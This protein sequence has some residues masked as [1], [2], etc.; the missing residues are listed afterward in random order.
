MKNICS[1]LL[2]FALCFCVALTSCSENE[3]QAKPVANDTSVTTDA[4]STA[5]SHVGEQNASEPV[6]NTQSVAAVGI[7]AGCEVD[8]VREEIDIYD[9]DGKI[10]LLTGQL[11]YPVVSI[12]DDPETENIINSYFEQEKE[13]YY[14]ETE[15]MHS[16]SLELLKNFQSDYWNT[17][18]YDKKFSLKLV[19]SEFVSFLCHSDIYLGGVHPTPDE[20]GVTFSVSDGSLLTLEELFSDVSGMRSVVL[21]MIKSAVES[22]EA[23]P[24]AEYEETLSTLVDDRNF[25][26]ENDGITFICNVYVLF[27]YVCGIN[28]YTIPYGELEQYITFSE[29]GSADFSLFYSFDIDGEIGD[30]VLGYLDT[31]EFSCP[32]KK[33]ESCII[34]GEERHEYYIVPRFTDSEIIIE[35]VLYDENGNE[36]GTEVFKRFKNTYKDYC[37]KIT[38]PVSETK[39]LYRVT[40]ISGD[41]SASFDLKYTVSTDKPVKLIR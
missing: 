29:R 3:S 31:R 35:H 2:L 24:F 16:D 28:Y 20:Y 21:P 4:E 41:K 6:T 9:E 14:S 5:E 32:Y 26:L 17:F 39:A 37:L 23:E 7:V 40:V 11:V 27:P 30:D 10:L 15:K 12:A 13:R 38:C 8:F 25:F 34:N 19:N 33:T 36:I 1:I 22:G 18:V